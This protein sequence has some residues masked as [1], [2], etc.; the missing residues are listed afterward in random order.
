MG[1]SEEGVEAAWPSSG[2]LRRRGLPMGLSLAA[3]GGSDEAA[4]TL[5]PMRGCLERGAH[6]FMH[7]GL[8]CFKSL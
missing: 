7:R 1:L 6:E 4:D 3:G 8:R 5:R 2:S